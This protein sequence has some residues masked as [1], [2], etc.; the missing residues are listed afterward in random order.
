MIIITPVTVIVV[1][2]VLIIFSTM[3][4][5]SLCLWDAAAVGD[6]KWAYFFSAGASVLFLVAVFWSSSLGGVLVV[7]SGGVVVV[8]VVFWLLCSG[9]GSRS[10][11]S[12]WLFSVHSIGLFL[13]CFVSFCFA[14]RLISSWVELQDFNAWGCLVL[15]FSDTSC[16]SKFVR[17]H[18]P[19]QLA[20][21][22]HS[23]S[24][25]VQSYSKL[26]CICCA[27]GSIPQR[28]WLLVSFAFNLR[29]WRHYF[30]S[31]GFP[32]YRGTG[33]S[34]FQ[35]VWAEGN[36][37]CGIFSLGHWWGAEVSCPGPKAGEK[38]IRSF[39]FGVALGQVWWEHIWF[40]I[41]GHDI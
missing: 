9:G 14:H 8:A 25:F 35:S 13:L 36:H 37:A 41:K 22:V 7:L 18:S 23:A 34:P 17:P 19:I 3:T 11:C 30:H 26:N 32:S 38:A 16:W 15:R 39:I 31:V 10:G 28:Y 6:L 4:W 24:C 5:T 12:L 27:V 1:V 33:V 29:S 40:M 2:V 20:L 21:R